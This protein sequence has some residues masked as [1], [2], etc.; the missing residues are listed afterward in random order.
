MSDENKE[1]DYS[2]MTK[3]DYYLDKFMTFMWFIFIV[4]IVFGGYWK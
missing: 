2:K 1:R 4:S 3:F